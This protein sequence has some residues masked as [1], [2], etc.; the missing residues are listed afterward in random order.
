MDEISRFPCP[1]TPCLIAWV[2]SVG[3]STSRQG[4]TVGNY[5]G[6]TVSGLEVVKTVAVRGTHWYILRPLHCSAVAAKTER[7]LARKK[8]ATKKGNI[9]FQDRRVCR[10][11]Q[12]R[13][14]CAK[15]CRG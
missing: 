9:S 5:S 1:S 6:P 14:C 4:E 15:E 3:V 13:E 2:A 12:E 11:E 10:G 7:A 8:M